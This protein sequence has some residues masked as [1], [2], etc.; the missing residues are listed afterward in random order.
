M[1]SPELA[2]CCYTAKTNE[3]A[4]IVFSGTTLSYEQYEPLSYRLAL[5]GY[6][7]LALNLPAHGNDINFRLGNGA[8]LLA[9][10]IR[11]VNAKG[12]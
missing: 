10:A 8:N 2:S 4:I 3:K 6:L 9:D 5:E 12:Y 1:V 11:D 7:V